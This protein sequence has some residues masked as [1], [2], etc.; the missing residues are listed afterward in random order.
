MKKAM[1]IMLAF[2]L[3]VGCAVAEFNG[4]DDS[5]GPKGCD[6][7]WGEVKGCD[8]NY[9]P[10][11][12]CVEIC[13]GSKPKDKCGC[14][15]FN[16][17]R[18]GWSDKV[19]PCNNYAVDG[20]KGAFW[21]MNPWEQSENCKIF[22]KCKEC[23]K[24]FCDGRCDECH[25]KCCV[26][27]YCPVCG[28]KYSVEHADGFCDKCGRDCYCMEKCEKCGHNHYF[29]GYCDHCADR[30]YYGRCCHQP[31]VVDNHECQDN[32]GNC[33]GN[34]GCANSETQV[35]TI[36]LGEENADNAKSA[37]QE[38]YPLFEGMNPPIEAEGKD[39]M[40]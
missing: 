20:Y 27:E 30:C 40:Q 31:E 19:E 37:M 14:H 32:I 16:E 34:E 7:K 15:H 35:F 25:E 11:V 26:Y 5:A 2:A 4:V 17:G 28:V 1:L 36:F 39:Q 23:G 33:M 29:N 9:R 21:L 10:D 18:C 22:E 24:T 8:D 13:P 6:D 12:L 38:G 3:L